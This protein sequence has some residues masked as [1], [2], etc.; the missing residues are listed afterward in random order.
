MIKA[1]NR[2]GAI[3]KPELSIQDQNVTVDGV[4]VIAAGTAVTVYKSGVKILNSCIQGFGKTQYG[5]GIWIFQQALDPN[6]KIIIDGNQLN[7]WGGFM[8]SGGIA[9]GK[10][11][12]NYGVPTEISVEVR[13]NRITGGPIQS[14][15]YN[16]A[17]QSFHPFLAYKNYVHTVSGTSFQNKTFNSRV[18]CNEAVN[19]IG[20]GALYNRSGSHNVWEY[21]IVHDL[22]VGI[23]HFMGDGNVYRG[24]VIYNVDYFGRVKDQDIG[25][26]NL[27][28]ENN[29]FHSSAAWASFIW[30][31]SSGGVISNVLWRNNIFHTTSGAAISTSSTL[32]PVWDETYNIFFKSIRPT[33]TT[34]DSGTSLSIDP[35]FVNPPLDFTIQEPSASGKGATWPLPCPYP[36]E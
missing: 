28:F 23:D 13:N 8:Y 1:V 19:V 5:N 27:L 36:S 29:T 11:D 35:R 20:D 34:G 12:D 4:S 24:N 2:C 10:A 18:A 32:D 7:D 14:G 6:N 15:I 16:A 30:D 26:T 22:E 9:I 25:S 31:N 3:V 33:G 21:N 17:I